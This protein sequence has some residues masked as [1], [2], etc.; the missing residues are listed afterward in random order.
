[1]PKTEQNDANTTIQELK[2]LV[3]KFVTDRHWQRHQAPKNLVMN[4]AIEAAELMEH[5]VWEREGK[6]D[7]EEVADELADVLFNVLNFAQQENIDITTAF[8]NKYQ[9]IIKK[10]PLEKFN[11]DRDD[12]DEYRRIRHI[13]RSGKNKEQA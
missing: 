5:Y 4:I 2:E 6:P 12:L 11:E 13:Y 8:I 10:Y 7:S 9:K 3:I 1:M